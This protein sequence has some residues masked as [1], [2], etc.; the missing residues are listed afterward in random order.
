MTG[1]GVRTA[2]VAMGCLSL[3]GALVVGISD[4]PPGIA[5]LYGGMVCLVLAAVCRWQRPRSFLLLLA[6]SAL[7]F[8]VFAILHNLL[9][10]LATM[11]DLAWLKG[12]I[13]ALHV[14]AFL[15]ALLLCPVGVLVGLVGWVAA[16][17]RGR[18]EPTPHH[19]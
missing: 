10:G 13:R 15:I 2:L 6:F 16:V 9:Y 17:F 3:G 12:M 7:G 8:V 5:L 14:G 18:R 1:F 4:N 19:S 11:V